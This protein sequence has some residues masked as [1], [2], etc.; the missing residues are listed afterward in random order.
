MEKVSFGHR[1][2]APDEK[3]GLVRAVFGSVAPNYDLMNDLMSGGLHRIWK[4]V[5]LDRLNPQP[6]QILADLAG[7][8]GDIATGFLKRAA[9][10]P[11]RDRDEARAIIIDINHAMLEAGQTRR[12]ETDPIPNLA[13]V[14]GDAEAL[15]L[16][17][18][19]IDTYTIGF[20][21]RN[22]T[23]RDRALKE[24]FRVLKRGGRFAC[25][26]FSRPVTP[27][28]ESVY[29][30]Y[31]DTVI[32]RLGEVVADDRESYEYLVESIRRFPPQDAFAA[33]V[34]AAGFSR[35]T[36]ENLTAGVVAIHSGG[37][38][39]AMIRTLIDLGRLI[40][41]GWVLSRYDA[42]IP[43]E[44]AQLTPTPVQWVG[45]VSRIGARGK[46]LRPGQRLAKALAGQGPAYVKFGQLLATRPDIVGFEM[47]NDLGELQD[48]M[49]PFGSDVAKAEIARAIGKPVDDLF[50]EFSEPIAAAS[51]AQV[52]KAR[53][54]DGSPVAVKVLRPQI[55]KK[56]RLEFRAF[57]LGARI[58]ERM[59]RS[60]R[61]MEPVKFIRTLSE[62]AEVELDLRI[63]A[64][65][66]SELK[67]NLHGTE[68]VRVPEV[69]WD[70]SA[71]RVLT[72]EWIDGIGILLI[73]RFNQ[74]RDRA[75]KLK[76]GEAATAL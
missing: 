40:R 18:N 50:T 3:V 54:K 20:G 73:D 53:L 14:C 47:A 29:Q 42:L 8:T 11:A 30:Q 13:C 49:P 39:N 23:Y 33:E 65:S 64:G 26:E 15:P 71:R 46:G 2:V 61:R 19:S 37:R 4:D 75:R 48:R 62:A 38:S 51:V 25:L 10:R 68:G 56:A 17:D 67:E 27:L 69:I 55:E 74:R 35:V 34:K 58:I 6:G 72:V 36:V 7:G 45:A 1:D 63:E 5:L 31:S 28:I 52:H 66:A 60:A 57:L 9:D 21:I 59:I 24:A 16:P 32:P 44:F 22:V 41:A 76:A 12:L 70:L 43:R